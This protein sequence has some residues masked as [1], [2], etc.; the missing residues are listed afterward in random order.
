MSM[1]EVSVNP[2]ELIETIDYEVEDANVIPFPIDPT[3]TIQGEAADA[4]ATGDAISAIVSN[5]R[6]N[7][8]SAE[9]NSF[10]LYGSDIRVTSGEGTQTIDQ[11][12]DEL[13]DRNAGDI[14]Y[15]TENLITIG[16]KIS[17]IDTAINTGL[18]TE[19]I[20]AIFDEV[21]EVEEDESDGES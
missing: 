7:S 20:D 3:L 16:T 8:K 11:A 4:K 5:M 10:T 18:S 19:D 2:E 12:I 21:F 1:S 17:E 9:N 14:L 13:S 15:D 6:I